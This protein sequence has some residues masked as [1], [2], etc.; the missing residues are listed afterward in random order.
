[1]ECSIYSFYIIDTLFSY[2]DI[3][4]LHC[5]NLYGKK[6]YKNKGDLTL[7]LAWC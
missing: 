4:Q 3:V 7:L 2:F 1:M 6:R 5:Y